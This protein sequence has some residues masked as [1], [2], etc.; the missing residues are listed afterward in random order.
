MDEG[1][2]FQKAALRDAERIK[3]LARRVILHN[4]VPFL[5][6]E[7]VD[8]FIS[9][10]MADK[11]IDDGL[12]RCSVLF[13]NEALL[14]FVITK[15]DLLHLIMLDVP[16]QGR[17]YGGRLLALA[18]S[19]LFGRHRTIRLQT[20]KENADAVRFYLKNGWRTAGEQFIEEM[21]LTMLSFEKTRKTSAPE[22]CL[23]SSL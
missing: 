17:G 10:G 14:G 12:D 19:E 7:A 11:E 16:F 15:D 1:L 22:K 3:E 4:Y 2:Y 18:E 6:A 21:N 9:S 23:T 5:G 13:L 20:F 8:A